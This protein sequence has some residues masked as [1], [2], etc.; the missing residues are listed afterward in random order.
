MCLLLPKS[1]VQTP[2][3]PVF[4]S[5]VCTSWT[6]ICSK[7]EFNCFTGSVVF[8][9]SHDYTYCL[10]L[11]S[12]KPVFWDPNQWSFS[13]CFH[14]TLWADEVRLIWI[15]SF[16][17]FA[18]YLLDFPVKAREVLEERRKWPPAAFLHLPK[19]LKGVTALQG[20]WSGPASSRRELEGKRS[21]D[22]FDYRF[23]CILCITHPVGHIIWE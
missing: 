23:P 12:H 14:K 22:Y 4:T 2:E 11:V 17:S 13:L 1:S 20:S 5:L 10:V 16:S 19:Y 7:K 6:S 3:G 21:S 8:S 18:W 15:Q 9:C